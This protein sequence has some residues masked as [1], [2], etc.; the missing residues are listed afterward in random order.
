LF[1]RK[2]S[3]LNKTREDTDMADITNKVRVNS[4]TELELLEAC[5]KGDVINL[6]ELAKVDVSPLRRAIAEE[7]DKVYQNRLA[8]E[9]EKWEKDSEAK[10]SKETIVLKDEQS[11]KE[12]NLKKQIADLNTALSLLKQENESRKNNLPK[13]ISAAKIQRQ[14]DL[15]EK[16]KNL[17]A[18]NQRL[19]R[20]K[21]NLEK[22]QATE[23]QLSLKEQAEK[24][25]SESDSVLKAKDGEINSLKREIAQLKAAHEAEMDK[26]ITLIKREK[27]KDISQLK[28]DIL[29][30]EGES[31]N[32]LLLQE[33]KSKEEYQKLLD[34]YNSLRYEKSSH[35]VKRLGE[36]L[37]KWCNDEYQHY[38]LSGFN[39]CLWLKDN[40]TVR[41][42]GTIGVGGT[43]ADYLFGVFSDLSDLK[44]V[45][46]L[47]DRKK[48]PSREKAMTSVVRDR[49]N[50]DP[51]SVNRKTNASYFAKLDSDRKKK[52]CEYALLVSELERDNEN[53]SFIT[54]AQGYEKRYVVR[55]PYLMTFLGMLYSLTDHYR[56]LLNQKGAEEVRLKKKQE[57]LDEFDALKETYFE[58]PLAQREKD[59]EGILKNCAQIEKS[60]NDIRTLASETLNVKISNRRNKIET[61]ELKKR[62]TVRNKAD[63]VEE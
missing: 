28:N 49:K 11:K 5:N 40:A 10:L 44:E 3:I 36:G 18:E 19:T 31:R 7:K 56:I 54:K 58:K 61:F 16:R 50:E 51:N 12:D 27:D 4:A 42:D 25:K 35:N 26:K 60:N 57:L 15:N 1:A 63:K 13:E 6:N 23:R 52:G 46:A 20:E 8:S 41:D 39:N 55:P 2:R 22:K 29:R 59:R 14:N 53:Y 33:K 34:Q 38:S 45:Q 37:E 47:F 62:K 32:S 21:D 17:E 30:K 9:K 48:N 43:K 24:R